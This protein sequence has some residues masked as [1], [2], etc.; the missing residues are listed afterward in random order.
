MWIRWNPNAAAGESK[1][2]QNFSLSTSSW[3][4]PAGTRVQLVKSGLQV[5]TGI[6]RD[7]PEPVGC[8]HINHFHTDCP[9]KAAVFHK[10]DN[11]SS[12]SCSTAHTCIVLRQVT[13]AWHCSARCSLLLSLDWSDPH[14][15]KLIT[16]FWCLMNS[17]AEASETCARQ[18]VHM[19]RDGRKGINQPN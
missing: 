9:T 7:E 14:Y 4:Q 15:Q 5:D 3:R 16:A 18:N 1:L 17:L 11:E 13:G 8:W 12:T 6:S 2:K 19:R 10:W